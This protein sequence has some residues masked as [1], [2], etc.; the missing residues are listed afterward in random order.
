MWLPADADP[1]LEARRELKR[2]A[3]KENLPEQAIALQKLLEEIAT[4]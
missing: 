1:K 4:Q 2:L 3:K